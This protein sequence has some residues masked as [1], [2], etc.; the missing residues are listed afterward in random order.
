MQFIAT[1]QN[2]P[3]EVGEKNGE[4]EGMVHVSTELSGSL[5]GQGDQGHRHG[6]G[7]GFRGMA[8]WGDPLGILEVPLASY[9]LEPP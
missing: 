1:P 2:Y 8:S 3:V 5:H 9:V 7:R 4:R 6:K